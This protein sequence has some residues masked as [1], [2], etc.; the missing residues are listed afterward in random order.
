MHWIVTYDTAFPLQEL[1]RQL[2]ELGLACHPERGVV[3]LNEQQA[4]LPAEG[5]FAAAMKVKEVPGVIAIGADAQLSLT[6]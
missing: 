2:V 5:E 3:G 1:C 6:K 4:I